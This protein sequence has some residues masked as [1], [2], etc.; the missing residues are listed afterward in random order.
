MCDCGCVYSRECVWVK[1][2]ILEC[3]PMP[4]TLVWGRVSF[5][6]CCRCKVCEVVEI[7]L[8]P[9]LF[10]YKIAGI[11]DSCAMQ[12]D[13]TRVLGICTQVLMV[14]TACTFMHNTILFLQHLHLL[15]PNSLIQ[16]RFHEDKLWGQASS[17][18]MIIE[19]SQAS[20]LIMLIFRSS[21]T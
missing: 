5:F 10:L 4:S 15:F 13:F 2:E 1:E 9:P 17:L 7:L 21:Q 20:D 14:C 3:W 6:L 18:S 12:P 11:I 8:S 16:R 19:N